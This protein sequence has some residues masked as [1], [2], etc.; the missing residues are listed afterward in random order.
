MA[1][2]PTFFTLSEIGGNDVLGYALTGGDGTNTITPSAG[3][4]GVGFDQT[5]GALIATLTSGGAKGL[6]TNVPNLA[7]LPHFTTVPFAPLD[8]TNEAFG[9][10]IPTLNTV[11]GAL[12]GVYAFLQS[13]G[14]ITDAAQEQLLSLIQQQ[15]PWLL[16]M[17]I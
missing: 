4:P 1:Q 6:V 2:S 16:K 7:D 3:P 14:A 12:N 9:P 13:Q 8:P 5:F 17:K 15:V 10:L 11:Y